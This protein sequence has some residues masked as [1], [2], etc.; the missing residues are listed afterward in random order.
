[1]E[2][3]YHEGNDGKCDDTYFDINNGFII[4]D[5][6]LSSN[7]EKLIEILYLCWWHIWSRTKFNV[8]LKLINMGDVK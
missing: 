1:M 3:N 5:N 6:A 8:A 7:F 4:K 2:E